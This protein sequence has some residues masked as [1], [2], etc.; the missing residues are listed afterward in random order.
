MNGGAPGVGFHWIGIS[1]LCLPGNGFDLSFFGFRNI[2]P[3]FSLTP[4]PS[5]RGRG[6]QGPPSAVAERGTQGQM[7]IRYR[8]TAH[9]TSTRCRISLDRHILLGFAG[10]W[11]RLVIFE[12]RTMVL[13]S[14][15]TPARPSTLFRRV[16]PTRSGP[17][18]RMTRRMVNG[19]AQVI[20]H[21]RTFGGSRPART[22]KADLRPLDTYRKRTQSN[23]VF[24]FVGPEGEAA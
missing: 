2:G 22:H 3:F 21:G 9:K 11:V 17:P 13:F 12:F 5:P 19:Y 6:E 14:S 24:G 16:L 1:S 7:W 10:K 23:P 8:R 20:R 15:L 18:R 4:G